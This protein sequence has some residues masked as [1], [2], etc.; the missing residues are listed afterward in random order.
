MTAFNSKQVFDDY[1]KVFI[2]DNNFQGSFTKDVRREG[3]GVF[4]I[5]DMGGRGGGELRGW[6]T[7]C[8]LYVPYFRKY[9]FSSFFSSCKFWKENQPDDDVY[10]GSKSKIISAHIYVYVHVFAFH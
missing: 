10:S 8:L 7:L 9:A 2:K 4:E 6:W 5:V 1:Y 3:G